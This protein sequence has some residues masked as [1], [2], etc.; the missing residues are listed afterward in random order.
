MILLQDSNDGFPVRLTYD[1]T[2]PI[3]YPYRLE[4]FL[5]RDRDFAKD[6]IGM[7]KETAINLRDALIKA[8]PLPEE[9]NDD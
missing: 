3:I 9:A 6:T 7:T 5:D 2:P 1:D 8:L 4:Q